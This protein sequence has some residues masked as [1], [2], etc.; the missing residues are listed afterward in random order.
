MGLDSKKI[1]STLKQ[2]ENAAKGAIRSLN[3]LT[4]N[5][6]KDSPLERDPLANIGLIATILQNA[7][8][9][10]AANVRFEGLSEE[11]V[12]EKQAAEREAEKEALQ[13]LVQEKLAKRQPAEPV[14]V[15][16]P[17]A[18]PVSEEPHQV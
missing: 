8:E 6:F 10:A 16:E 2:L 11:E 4:D 7:K 18:E 9:K 14:V 3:D 15:E 5:E 13:T 12:A 17:A 1:D